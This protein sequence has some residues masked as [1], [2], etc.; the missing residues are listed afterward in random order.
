MPHN[1]YISLKHLNFLSCD[2]WKINLEKFSF[3]LSHLYNTCTTEHPKILNVHLMQAAMN[4]I[5]YIY[6]SH[7]IWKMTLIYSLSYFLCADFICISVGRVVDICSDCLL[8][9][10]SNIVKNLLFFLIHMNEWNCMI[11]EKQNQITT[12]N[13]WNVSPNKTKQV[14]FFQ[15]SVQWHNT[16]PIIYD[17][18]TV[19]LATWLI[20]YWQI[21]I[22]P[23]SLYYYSD[24]KWW[25]DL[26]FFWFSVPHVSRFNSVSVWLRSTY[27]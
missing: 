17:R 15:K 7:F 24:D 20:I 2:W 9:N 23:C 8:Q 25:W 3:L 1:Y 5:K 16:E 22:V 4:H 27:M 6:K 11:L 18:F 26:F 13:N 21:R 10:T 19:N 14:P 12:I